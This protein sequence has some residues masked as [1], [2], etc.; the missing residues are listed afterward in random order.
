MNKIYFSILLLFCFTTSLQTSAKTTQNSKADTSLVNSFIK[1]A[2]L[3]IN[4]GELDSAEFYFKRAGQLAKKIGFTKGIF[5]YLQ[6]S[7]RFYHGQLR[8]NEALTVSKEQLALSIKV[9]DKV[10]EAASYNNIGLQYLSLGMY[11][12]TADNLLKALKLSENLNDLKNQSKYYSNLGSLFIDLKDKKKSLYYAK[13]GYEVALKLKDKERI[14]N[15]LINLSYSEYLAEAYDNSI[16]YLEEAIKIALEIKDN[17]LLMNA[18]INKAGAYNAKNEHQKAI[19]NLSAVERILKSNPNVDFELYVNSEYAATYHA[20]KNDR[21]AL[22]YFNKIIKNAE[23]LM[24]KHDLIDVYNLGAEINENLKKTEVALAYWKKQTTLSDS[25]LNVSSQAAIQEAEIKYQ[26]SVK[27]KAIAQQ[28]LQLIDKNYDL[29]KKNKYILFGTIAILLLLFICIIVYLIYRNK[30]QSIELSL[31]KAQI[32]PHF[33][34]NTLNNLYALCLNKSN[35]SPGVVLGL[36]EIL[37]Y[38]LYECNTTNVNLGKEMEIIERYIALEKI[39]YQDRLEVNL[40]TLGKLGDYQI[41]PLLILPLVENAFKH[42]ISK[43]ITEGWININATMRGTDFVF[44]ISNNKPMVNTE[45]EPPSRYGNIGLQNIKKRLDILY[46]NQHQIKVVSEQD[47]FIV[48]LK[49]KLKKKA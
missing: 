3:K 44:K 14:G 5:S 23:L 29:Q 10:K 27:E 18:Y 28:K 13:K 42:G 7:A 25:L 33:L 2:H 6:E 31:L 41:V 24:P 1:T 34:F 35:E 43:I 21:Q 47:V 36:A 39:R 40:S 12:L 45:N 4:K 22:G 20:L 8:F 9:K 15:S 11:R 26:T 16:A 46:P 38:I 48:T 32:H 19:N 17:E 37:R 49:I 30:N